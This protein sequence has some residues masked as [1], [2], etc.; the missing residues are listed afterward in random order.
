MKKLQLLL[1]CFFVITVTQA[2][3]GISTFTNPE[4]SISV[5]FG[6]RDAGEPF[7]RV[8]RGKEVVLDTSALGITRKDAQFFKDLAIISIEGPVSVSD[9]YT[10][11]Q[12]KQQQIEYTANQYQVHLENAEGEPLDII[13]N[14]SDDGVAF[15]YYFPNTSDT[16]YEVTEEATAYHF[17]DET[18]AWVQPMSVAKTGWMRTNPSY[19]EHY[20]MGVDADTISPLGQGWVYPALF[21]TGDTWALISETD[22]EANYCGSRLKYNAEN[23]ALQLTFPQESEVFTNGTLNPKSTLPLYSPWRIITIGSLKTI[24]E[25]TLGTDL[26]AP[27]IDMDTSF[28]KPGFASWSWVL[29]KDDSVNYETTKDFIDYASE[30]NWPYCLVDADWNKRIGEERIKKLADYASTK[31]VKLLLWYNS[32]GEWNDTVYEPKS[33][34]IS[35][36]GRKAEFKK[37]HDMGIAGIKVD[38]FGGDGQS[39]IAYYHDILKDAAEYQLL[40]NFHG[41]T[42]PRGWQRTYPHLMTTEAIKGEEFITFGQET[43]DLQPSHNAMLPFTRNAFDPMDFTPMVLDSIPNIQ[44]RT[45]AAFEL[46]LPVIFLSGIQHIAEIPQGMNKMPDYVVELLKDVPTDW[47]ETRFLDGYPGKDAVIARRKDKTWFIAAING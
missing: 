18:K 22:L 43:A 44:R 46:A 24:V 6:L 8:L 31:G 41:A 21:K 1:L 42:L 37:L 3:K 30:M 16:V 36:E 7:Y 40:M 4:K 20:L 11:L 23:D 32:S 5:T 19:E 47:T 26:A 39:M 28:I 34:L 10:M 14:L 13:F 9:N 2:Q 38:F 33:A 45:T 17:P 29:L 15:R 27:A 25:S 12:G 35:P